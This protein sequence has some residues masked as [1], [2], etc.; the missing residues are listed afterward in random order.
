MGKN[1]RQRIGAQGSSKPQSKGNSKLKVSKP[2]PKKPGPTSKP[3]VQIQHAAP[4]IPFSPEE[5]ILLIGEA[6]LSFARS[7]IEHHMCTNVTATVL[8]KDLQELS[9]KYPHVVD[10]IAEME[11]AGGKIQYGV[12]ATKMSPWLVGAKGDKGRLGVMNKIFFNFP[13]VGGKS[14]DVNR[15]VRYN[16]GM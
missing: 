6:D 16:Q 4:T 9:E 2:Q 5:K 15:Q 1:K 11:K 10:N 12:D 14:T 13:H 3:H 7:L 8:E